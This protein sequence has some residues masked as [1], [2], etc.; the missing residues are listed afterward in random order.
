MTGSGTSFPARKVR[1]LGT[2]SARYNLVYVDEDVG[3]P[4]FVMEKIEG[5]MNAQW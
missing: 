2:H 5:F 1:G 4:I 3:P